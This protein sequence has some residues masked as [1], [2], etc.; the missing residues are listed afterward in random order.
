MT[1]ET[2]KQK[3]IDYSRDRK[4]FS[5]EDLKR[6]FQSTNI[7]YTDESVKKYLYNFQKDH[8]LYSAGR[9]W[10]STII[11]PFQLESE[12]IKEIIVKLKDHFQILPF[13]C[14]STQQIRSYFHHLPGKFVTFIY[15]DADSLGPVF[16]YLRDLYP[17]TYLNPAKN[18]VRK[19]FLIQENT[20]VL[21][22][23][24]TE[25]P[26]DGH[27]ARIEKILVDLYFEKE[28]I[29][30]ID[31]WEYDRIFENIVKQFRI[32]AAKLVRYAKRR[33]MKQ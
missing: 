16:D 19:N 1:I 18:E 33:E 17:N 6:Y 29:N 28:R 8:S 5:I 10:Y 13:S 24:I 31:G 32:D 11:T 30:L 7:P 22:H 27:Y 20:I 21:R 25:E 26:R 4:Y 3:I 15:T 12:P 2:L 23:E 9:G 14:W